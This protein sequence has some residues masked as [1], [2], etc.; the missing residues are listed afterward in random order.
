M[1]ENGGTWQL[2]QVDPISGFVLNTIGLSRAGTVAGLAWHAPTGSF[3]VASDDS[4]YSFSLGSSTVSLW[5]TPSG[6]TGS[7]ELTGI[8]VSRS[9]VATGTSTF[10]GTVVD[11]SGIPQANVAVVLPGASTTTA[12]D[13]TF[14]LVFVPRTDQVRVIA[15]NSNRQAFSQPPIPTLGG[16]VEVGEIVLSSYG[17]E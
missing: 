8:A 1:T 12:A 16:T 15:K 6:Q 3:L 13:G 17:K 10:T 5:S 4:I 9:G 2:Y 11:D 14:S 7:G